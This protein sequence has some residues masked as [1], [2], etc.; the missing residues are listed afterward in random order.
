MTSA[1][2]LATRLRALRLAA[3]FP[4]QRALAD[5]AGLNQ[6]TIALIET[7]R[8]RNPSYDTIDKLAAALGVEAE[9]L[10]AAP[11]PE[12][13]AADDRQRQVDAMRISFNEVPAL[14]FNAVA[15]A[16]NIIPARVTG[17]ALLPLHICHGDVLLIEVG[18]VLIEN[19]I[20]ALHRVTPDEIFQ[21]FCIRRR[22]HMG[23]SVPPQSIAKGVLYM[24]GP[25]AS[26]NTII[27]ENDS[28]F[29]PTGPVVGLYRNICGEV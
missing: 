28:Q 16:G 15:V 17:D 29:K 7:G 18:G 4:T 24:I 25:R 12:D 21:S 14:N 10:A 22:V 9:R 11:K 13:A 3:G 19:H 5:A 2:D 6:S 20:V 8:A 27:G 1:S 23:K 26:F